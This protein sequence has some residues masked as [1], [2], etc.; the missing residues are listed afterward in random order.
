MEPGIREPCAQGSLPRLAMWMRVPV[1]FH[2]IDSCSPHACTSQLSRVLSFW[3]LSASPSPARRVLGGCHVRSHCTDVCH[4]LRPTSPAPATPIHPLRS[5]RPC[6]DA[7]TRAPNALSR[8]QAGSH[9]AI[10]RD[11]VGRRPHFHPCQASWLL[12]CSTE[13][14]QHLYQARRGR[15]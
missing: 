5:R 9:T 8:H 12:S 6:K 3:L 10:A 7:R 11:V 2:I 4:T 1:M 14:S 13:R 15:P